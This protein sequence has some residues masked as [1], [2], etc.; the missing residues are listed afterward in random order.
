MKNLNR[1]ILM[2][3]TAL[4]LMTATSHAQVFIA[5]DEFEGMLRKGESEY[6]LVAPIQAL[7]SDQ[8]LPIGDG[9]WVLTCLG[10]SYLLKKRKKKENVY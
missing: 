8:Y 6:V 7:D 9:L 2:V 4:L 3:L 1:R 5:D 10:A